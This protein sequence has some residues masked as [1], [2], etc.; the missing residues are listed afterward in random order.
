MFVRSVV[1]TTS[2]RVAALPDQAVVDYEGKP[3]VLRQEPSVSGQQVFRMMEVQRGEQADGYS[4]VFI[5]GG[6]AAAAQYVIE[7]AYSLLSKLK[8][9]GEE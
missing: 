9:A 6:P 4:E 3:F 7:G 2:R 1:E 5:S 8:N